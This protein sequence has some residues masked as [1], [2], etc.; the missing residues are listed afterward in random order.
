MALAPAGPIGGNASSTITSVAFHLIRFTSF[1]TFPS[2]G[3]AW[4]NGLA[5]RCQSLRL[6]FVSNYTP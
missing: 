2:E 5:N 1:S 3:K 4:V 6:F